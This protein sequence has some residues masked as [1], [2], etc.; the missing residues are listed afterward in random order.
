MDSL[1]DLPVMDG[2]DQSPQER[3]VMSKYFGQAS[4]QNTGT[5]SSG[6]GRDLKI[7]GVAALL[8]LLLSNPLTDRFMM[9]LPYIGSN[10]IGVITAKVAIF[11]IIFMIIHRY[12]V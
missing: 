1:S 2:A 9:L 4:S 12:V 5:T 8:F 6:W 11:F 7:S 10:P 3:D